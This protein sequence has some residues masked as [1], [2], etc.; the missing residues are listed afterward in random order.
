MFLSQKS[1]EKD[2]KV[3]DKNIRLEELNYFTKVAEI[4]IDKIILPIFF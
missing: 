4:Q 2:H 3:E 1:N